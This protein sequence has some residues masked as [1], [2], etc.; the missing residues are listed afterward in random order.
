MGVEAQRK[1]TLTYKGQEKYTERK[2]LFKKE[3]QRGDQ[4][5]KEWKEERDCKL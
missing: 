5:R 4:I 1:E 2:W 3:K